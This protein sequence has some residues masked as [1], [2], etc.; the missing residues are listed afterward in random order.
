[1]NVHDHDCCINRHG[2]KHPD[3]EIVVCEAPTRQRAIGA[4]PELHTQTRILLN[5]F[6]SLKIAII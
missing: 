5:Q 1:M 2:M 4:A 3:G 6:Y